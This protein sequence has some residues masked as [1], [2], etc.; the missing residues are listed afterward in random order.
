MENNSV[1]ISKV[2]SFFK[3]LNEF[4]EYS[5][6]YRV[7]K[8]IGNISLKSFIMGNI[9]KGFII[10]PHNR[11]AE[12]SLII[13]CVFNI[14]N[15]IFYLLR[16][17]YLFLAKV[18]LKSSNKYLFDKVVSPLTTCEKGVSAFFSALFGFFF[19][20]TVISLTFGLGLLPIIINV[21]LSIT[22]FILA[23]ID[24]SFLIR[25]I[26]GCIPSK[27]LLWLYKE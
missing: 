15:S 8:N 26:K 20:R 5:I 1:I 12:G 17:F 27:I 4:Y 9:Y 22:F 14:F 18:N 16:K 2:I 13:K 11:Y 21:I 25:T 24:F 23:F 10:H 19:I 7:F 6:T 3:I